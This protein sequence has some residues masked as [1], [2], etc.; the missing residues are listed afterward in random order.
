M[1]ATKTTES[2]GAYKDVEEILDYAVEHGYAACSFGTPGQATNFRHRCYRFR[3]LMLERASE[4]SA[5]T[6][7]A[8]PTTAYDELELIIEKENKNVVKI[9]KRV[10]PQLID[11]ETGKPLD[12]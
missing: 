3:N 10:R 2:V 12:I 5:M 7:G 8:T 6:P 1:K 9:R 11:P 4:L